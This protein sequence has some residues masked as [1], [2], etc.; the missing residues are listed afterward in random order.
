MLSP[1]NG[2]LP[3]RKCH[4]KVTDISSVKLT[5]VFRAGTVIQLR[6]HFC[7]GSDGCGWMAGLQEEG[8]SCVVETN[9]SYAWL[10][11]WRRMAALWVP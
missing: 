11:R 7:L 10:D 1:S 8:V 3:P 6:L 9:W 2:L 5:F 4:G